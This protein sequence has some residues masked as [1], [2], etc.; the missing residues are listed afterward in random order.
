MFQMA[1]QCRHGAARCVSVLTTP[2]CKIIY[3]HSVTCEWVTAV[4]QFPTRDGTARS[5]IARGLAFLPARPDT[6]GQWPAIFRTG[7]IFSRVSPLPGPVRPSHCRARA[8]VE[9]KK[10]RRVAIIARHSPG[11][12]GSPQLTS[13]P[14]RMAL[15]TNWS[16]GLISSVCVSQTGGKCQKRSEHPGDD[17]GVILSHFWGDQKPRSH[18]GWEL[19]KMSGKNYSEDLWRDGRIWSAWA[20]PAAESRNALN[21]LRINNDA[22]RVTSMEFIHWIPWN[23]LNFPRQEGIPCL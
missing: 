16:L 13:L 4:C 1:N 12:E 19:R 6:R 22:K 18:V 3:L 2:A 11:T 8:I 20:W 10:S 17:Q 5:T 23:N 15:R 21:E 14:S 7:A 9:L